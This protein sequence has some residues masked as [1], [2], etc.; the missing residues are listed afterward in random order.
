MRNRAE[1]ANTHS[2]DDRPY[3]DDELSTAHLNSGLLAAGSNL[4]YSDE[5]SPTPEPEE[6]PNTD[7][8]RVLA[9]QPEYSEAFDDPL[10]EPAPEPSGMALHSV[11]PRI[12]LTIGARLTQVLRR[13]TLLVILGALAAGILGAGIYGLTFTSWF[14]SILPPA[15]TG[16]P[17]AASTGGLT[18]PAAGGGAPNRTQQ[19]PPASAQ[20]PAAGNQDSTGTSGTMGDAGALVA[21]GVEQYKLGHYSEAIGFLESAVEA[22]GSDAVINY[23]LGLAYMAANGREHGLEDAEMAFRTAASLQPTW[24]A[25]RRMLAESLIRRGYFSAALEPAQQAV[26]LGANEAE[27]W[28]TL[29]RA[30]KGA[31]RASEATRAFAEAARLSPLPPSNP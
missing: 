2:S 20:P 9:A 19:Q 15:L 13:G 12:S 31:G 26:Q 7:W 30:N 11:P 27:N 8:L 22:D 5:Q 1:A 6:R 17:P 3:E 24:A 16:H 18:D 25:P 4:A 21:K 23:Q 14:S 10:P 29:G 28:M